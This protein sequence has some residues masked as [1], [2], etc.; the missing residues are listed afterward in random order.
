M[1]SIQGCVDG[2]GVMSLT[3]SIN[4]ISTVLSACLILITTVSKTTCDL[5]D[6]LFRLIEQTLLSDV[7]S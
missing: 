1:F 7:T 5:E 4:S 6:L 3:N 2:G